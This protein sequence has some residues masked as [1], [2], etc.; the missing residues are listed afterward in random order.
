MQPG[1][2]DL[3]SFSMHTKQELLLHTDMTLDI[4]MYPLQSARAASGA[5]NMLHF[6]VMATFLLNTGQLILPHCHSIYCVN[7]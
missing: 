5:L 1:S 4:H 2:S 6:L 7:T 3:P